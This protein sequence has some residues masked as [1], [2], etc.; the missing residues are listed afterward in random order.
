MGMI[1]NIVKEDKR[2]CPQMFD[3][4]T[5]DAKTPLYNGCT[6]FTKLLAVLKLFNLKARNGW[7]DKSFTELLSLLKEMLPQDNVL[8]C[9]MYEAKKMLSAIS[10]SYEKIHACPN[11]CILFQNEYAALDKC[12]KCRALRYKKNSA[13]M[14]V[15]WY[16]PIIPRFRPMYHNAQ[17]AKNLRWHAYERICDGKLRHPADSPQWEKVDHDYPNFG[18]EPRNLRLALSTDGINPHG[19]RSNSH[20]TWPVVM[21]IYNLPPWLCMKRKFMMLSMLIPGLKQIGNDIDVYLAPL[22]EDLKDMWNE[23]VEVY[24]GYM[25]ESFQLRAMLFGTINDFPPY[26]NLFGYSIKGK[27][28][29]P[30]CED[31]TDWVRLEHGKKNVFLGHRK[32]LTS[33]H[34][35]LGWRK[36]FNGT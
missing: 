23:G 27:C 11:D 21:I 6:S 28:A 32:F 22:I 24:D 20:S 10:M 16:F 7:T 15:V 31:N 2:D 34:R 14:K 13:P 35:Y 12:P 9:R 5:M 19:M 33:K 4:L 1:S 8:P 17:D 18:K 36:A 26:G 3:R 25:E 29:C 30:I